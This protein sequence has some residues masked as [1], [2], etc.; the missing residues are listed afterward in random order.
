MGKGIGFGVGL[1]VPVEDVVRGILEHR[2]PPPLF[3]FGTHLQ[4]FWLRVSRRACI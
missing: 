4:I 1:V 3:R 2:E